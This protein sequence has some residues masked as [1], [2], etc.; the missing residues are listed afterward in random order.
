MKGLLNNVLDDPIY[1]IFPVLTCISFYGEKK[2]KKKKNE[3]KI[4]NESTQKKKNENENMKESVEENVND[5]INDN[6][7][8]NVNDNMNES[9]EE[10]I[11]ETSCEETEQNDVSVLSEDIVVIEECN[12]EIKTDSEN[13]AEDT[14]ESLEEEDE[15]QMIFSKYQSNVLYFLFTLGFVIIIGADLAFQKGRG[16]VTNIFESQTFA[17]VLLYI[18]NFFLWIDFIRNS[19]KSRNTL[20][21]CRGEIFFNYFNVFPF[22]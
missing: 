17:Y 12:K 3:S 13:F 14:V 5:N 8:E 21:I 16:S 6:M 9:V 4:E 15:D 10:S 7:K 20:V 19:Q 18:I 22:Y 1:F 2:V 11:D